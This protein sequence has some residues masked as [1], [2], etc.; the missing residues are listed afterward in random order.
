MSPSTPEPPFFTGPHSFT[1]PA[2]LVHA[3]PNTLALR[4]FS[5]SPNGTVSP[6][7]ARMSLPI[8]TFGPD[9]DEWRHLV[10][11]E[12]PPL[13]AD[14][15]NSLPKSPDAQPQNT[16]TYIYNAQIAPLMPFAI[17]G[18]IWYQGENNSQ[19]AKQYRKI[20]PALIADWRGRW[21]EGSFPFYIVQLANY[22]SNPPQPGRSA[23][24]ELRESQ[25]LTAQKVPNTGLAVT[26]DVGEGDNI[27]PKDKQD[28]GKRLALVALAKTYGKDIPYS[29]PLFSAM[30]VT[31]DT[32]RLT[33]THTDGG[34]VAKGGPLKH[35]AVAGDDH[36][37][38]WA[39]AKISGDAVLVSSPQVPHPVAVRYA[40]ADD[41]EGCNLYN[42]AGL[43][44]SP[45]RTD[46]NDDAPPV[47]ASP[48]PASAL[49]KSGLL[50]NGDFSSPPVPA[51]KD[52]LVAR[53]DGWT[54]DLKGPGPVVA[55]AGWKPG[56]PPFLLWNDP[57]GTVAQT[58]DVKISPVGK[59]GSVYT[60]SYFYGGQGKGS[61][62]LVTSI[63]VDGKVAATDTKDVDVTKP[64]IDHP[65]TLT[66]TAKAADAGKSLGVS[67][68][69]TEPAGEHV[70]S[71]LRDVTL[72]VAP[73]GGTK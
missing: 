32:A 54:Y 58:A 16:A 56:R 1:V 71:G 6:D 3:G 26:V 38:V 25:L 7:T 52:Y 4:V 47:A 45:F 66:Y 61:Y 29:G 41:P 69:M 64:G 12:N 48:T 33:F 60:L 43:P 44:A 8:T 39:D 31:G 50:L 67:F 21:G 37:F 15:L 11:H 53:P 13:S 36:N 49:K 10:E 72:T 40:W 20:L 73:P 27:H 55:V 30:T 35:F 62:T 65:G 5:H 57:N 22:G 19:R 14:A 23:W 46:V 9:A 28:V 18:V 59:A 63:L 24:A 68:T 34:L 70:Q 51:G 42:A 17:K 2:D